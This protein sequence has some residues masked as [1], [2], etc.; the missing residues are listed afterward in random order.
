MDVFFKVFRLVNYI[1]RYH[2]SNYVAV[3]TKIIYRKGN[4]L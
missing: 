1:L 4:P 3:T 2:L